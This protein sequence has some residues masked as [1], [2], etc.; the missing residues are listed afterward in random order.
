MSDSERRVLLRV[1]SFVADSGDR[2]E[3]LIACAKRRHLL[4][5]YPR[6]QRSLDRPG[7]RRDQA[8][9]GGVAL[10]RAKPSRPAR[11]AADG[12]DNVR[13]TDHGT[14]V[15]WGR[16]A[17]KRSD[18]DERQNGAHNDVFR[19]ALSIRRPSA[20]AFARFLSPSERGEVDDCADHL[21]VDLGVVDL[22]EIREIEVR[23]EICTRA[24]DGGQHR[25]VQA[26][27]LGVVFPENAG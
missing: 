19:H 16:C 13:R 6:K 22:Q 15:Q 3:G 10:V 11:C 14:R 4:C 9:R 20:Q 5:A 7:R 25:F 8:F 23:N 18:A 21:A 24:D 1:R 12:S 2:F 27:E 17:R 26:F